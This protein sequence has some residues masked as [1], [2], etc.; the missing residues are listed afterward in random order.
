[1]A[2]PKTYFHLRFLKFLLIMPNERTLVGGVR[3]LP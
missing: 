3:V 2:V 1:M